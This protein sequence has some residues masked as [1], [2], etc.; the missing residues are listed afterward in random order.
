MTLVVLLFFLSPVI[1]G[2]C[3]WRPAPPALERGWDREARLRV[4]HERAQ[5][6]LRRLRYGR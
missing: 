6:E 1:V 3:A 5:R 4:T 2:L